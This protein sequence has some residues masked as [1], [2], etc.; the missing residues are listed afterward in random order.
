MTA[1][2]RNARRHRPS[3]KQNHEPRIGRSRYQRQDP[4]IH[5][6]AIGGAPDASP[7]RK[8]SHHDRR[9]ILSP[10]ALAVGADVPG[11]VDT[12]ARER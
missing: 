5:A 1:P 8:R 4:T 10:L 6:S 12:P 11:W 3:P 2:P 7:L 9:I